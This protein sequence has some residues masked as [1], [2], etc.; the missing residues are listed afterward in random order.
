LSAR[1]AAPSAVRHATDCQRDV[2]SSTARRREAI[3]SPAYSLAFCSTPRW[4]ASSPVEPP[5]PADGHRAGRVF[6]VVRIQRPGHIRRGR[7][8][9][10]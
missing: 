8:A 10:K 9:A 5:A 4:K 2:L 7:P 1:Y 6:P 3:A